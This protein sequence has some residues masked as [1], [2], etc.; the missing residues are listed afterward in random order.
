MG[1]FVTSSGVLSETAAAKFVQETV[2]QN[3]VVIFSKSTCPYCKMAKNVFSEIGTDY[4]V[5]ELDQH[6]SGSQLQTILGNMTGAKTVPRVFVNGS[7]IGGG[8]QTRRLHEEG[9]LL[10]LIQQCKPCS[11]AS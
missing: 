4:K 1:N 3:C 7:C 5:I 8:T 11:A 10:S 9:K 6:E 2:S